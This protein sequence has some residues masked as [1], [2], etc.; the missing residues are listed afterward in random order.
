[1]N[2]CTTIPIEKLRI[3]ERII[4]DISAKRDRADCVMQDIVE[5][6]C[7]LT[8]SETESDCMIAALS[9]EEYFI[10][11]CIVLDYLYEL[12]RY[13]QELDEFFDVEWKATAEYRKNPKESGA[14]K[15]DRLV[16]EREP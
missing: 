13:S 3:L 9:S 6:S 14:E 10:K 16:A 5:F 7:K 2:D 1:M 11:S 8:N 4:N 12:K 15:H